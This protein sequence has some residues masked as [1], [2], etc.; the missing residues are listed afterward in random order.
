MTDDKNNNNNHQQQ[1]RRGWFELSPVK[2]NLVAGAGSGVVNSLLC[3][4]LDVAKIRQ[5]LEGAYMAKGSS[6]R[7]NGVVSTLRIIYQEEGLKGWFRGIRPSLF[8]LPLFWAIYF[9]SYELAKEEFASVGMTGPLVHCASAMFGGLMS[10]FV[11]NPLWVVRTRMVSGIYHPSSVLKESPSVSYHMRH[12]VK[13]EGFL[14]LYK[15]LTASLLGLT[16]VGIQFPIY[17]K[18]KEIAL[19]VQMHGLSLKTLGL[20]DA[21]GDELVTTLKDGSALQGQRRDSSEG[22]ADG[23]ETRGVEEEPSEV[24]RVAGLIVASALSK[25]I[26]SSITYPHEVLRSRMQDSREPLGLVSIA[27]QILKA[28]GVAGLFRG[29][30]VNLVRVLPS[31]VTVFVSYEIIAH[32]MRKYLSKPSAI[33]E[34]VVA[35]NSSSS[36]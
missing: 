7:Y 30:K 14:A 16:H 19:D 6:Q 27:R 13:K 8:T 2:V 9:P 28:E 22:S 23:G 15:G 33:A 24:G 29:L 10:D 12:I 20:S 31:C 1:R 34:F 3:S 17:E 11:T 26:A 21:S 32:Q 25:G 35:D 36:E 5:Q 18:F 4:P